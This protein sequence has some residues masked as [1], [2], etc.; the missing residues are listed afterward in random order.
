MKSIRGKILLCMSLTLTI[1]LGILGITSLYLNYDSSMKMLEQTMAEVANVSAQRVG[2]ELTAYMNV[3][4]DAGCI[5]RLADPKQS[6]ENKK[7][8]VDQRASAHGFIRGNIIGLDGIS[9]FDGNNYT[10]R[11]YYQQAISGTPYISEPLISKISGEFSIIISAPLW[12]GGV[13]NT[14]PVGVIYFVPP[15]TFLNDIVSKINISQNSAAYAINSSG[16][17]IADNTMDTIMKQNIEEEAKQDPS[18]NRLAQIHAKMRNKENGFSKYEI[19]GVQK[20]SSYAPIPNTDNWS[21]GIT[22]PQKDF[23]SSTYISITITLAL[24]LTSLIIA[25]IIAYR[26]ANGIGQPIKTFSQRI[27]ALSLGDLKSDIPQIKS[28]DEIGT[29]A[30]A[31]NSIVKTFKDIITDIDWGLSE[32]AS[33]NFNITSKEPEMYVGD[34]K[35]LSDSMYKILGQLTSTLTQINQSSEQVASDS[36]QMTQG[37]QGLSDGATEQAAAVEELAAT[38]NEISEHVKKNATNAENVNLRVNNLKGEITQSNQRMQELLNAMLEISNS[39]NEISKIIK[40]IEDITFQTNL[41]SLNAAIEAARAGEA[42]KGFAVVADEVRNLATKSTEASKSTTQLIDSALQSIDNGTR[43]ANDTAQALLIVVEKIQ[44]VT[45]TI[46]QISIA[47]S[48]Q[49]QSIEQVT[50]GI[51]QI[52]GVVQ[53]NS[54]TAEEIAASSEELSGQA[55]LL[56]NL[57]SG[58]H[59]RKL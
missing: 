47:S 8:I 16:I 24:L 35:S 44:E 33:G 30:E 25:V 37:A 21:I 29:L 14:K 58:F 53:T 28:K 43:I 52:S 18:L 20:F 46:G 3:A 59:L 13:P 45:D 1:S 12:E 11:I 31:T 23:M 22:A 10:D 49:S 9:I 40:T 17:T 4:I 57:I 38:I 15:E 2:Q 56:K 55:Q 51:D 27:K 50:A 36:E 26:L 6:I 5:A 48:E 19:N 34:F 7:A 41:L 42:G 39:S 32:M 54:A